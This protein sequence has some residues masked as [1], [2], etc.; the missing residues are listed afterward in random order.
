MSRITLI[1]SLKQDELKKIEKLM[2]EIK[3]KTCKVFDKF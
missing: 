1:S 2:T 3:F